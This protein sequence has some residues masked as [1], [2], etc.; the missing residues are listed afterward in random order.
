MNTR[1]LRRR[2][3]LLNFFTRNYNNHYRMPSCDNSDEVDMMNYPSSYEAL[4]MGNRLWRRGGVKQWNDSVM[5]YYTAMGLIFLGPTTYREAVN[6]F[7]LAIEREG[8]T[9]NPRSIVLESC[10]EKIAA[11]DQYFK[12]LRYENE[13]SQVKSLLKELRSSYADI[14][15]RANDSYFDNMHEDDKVQNGIYA[16]GGVKYEH[17]LYAYYAGIGYLGFDLSTSYTAFTDALAIAQQENRSDEYIELIKSKINGMDTLFHHM[18]LESK[19]PKIQENALAANNLVHQLC[20]SNEKLPTPP[21]FRNSSYDQFLWE[22]ASPLDKKQYCLG[23]TSHLCSTQALVA[24]LE[25]FHKGGDEYNKAYEYF[26]SAK[27]IETN[28]HHTSINYSVISVCNDKMSEILKFN[29]HVE[30]LP[31]EPDDNSER[32]ECKLRRD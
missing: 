28:K 16:V 21:R 4:I 10:T 12:Y 7:N 31:F 25:C 8:Q 19:N 6:Y 3:T 5:T 24:A 11:V 1:I 20:F 30:Y 26:D 14:L 17:S 29:R 9:N 23:T 2:T 32:Q 15:P 18:D 27:R 22:H 13:V